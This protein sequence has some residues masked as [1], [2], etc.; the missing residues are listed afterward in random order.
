MAGAAARAGRTERRCTIH[1]WP[2]SSAEIA[3]AA[4]TAATAAAETATAAAAAAATA[5]AAPL[6]EQLGGRPQQHQGNAQDDPDSR[7]HG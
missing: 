7:F 1:A 4:V 3:A 5:A 6:R 2:G